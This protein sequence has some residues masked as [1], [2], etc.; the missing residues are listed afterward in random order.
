MTYNP[1]EPLPIS[2]EVEQAEHDIDVE[3]LPE[4]LKN[5]EAK[6]LQKLQDLAK[7]GDGNLD[8]DEEKAEARLGV[9]ILIPFPE[10][11]PDFRDPDLADA[12]FARSDFYVAEECFEMSH[13]ER[14]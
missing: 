10:R 7:A 1:S 11:T 2:G 9:E 13:G 8:D 6:T 3:L 5:F 14:S 12:N 4:E